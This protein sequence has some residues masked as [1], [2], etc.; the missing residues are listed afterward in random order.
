MGESNLKMLEKV[1]G[2]FYKLSL[3]L[4]VFAT[5]REILLGSPRAQL[6]CGKAYANLLQVVAN[7][8]LFYNKKTSCENCSAPSCMAK[9]LTLPFSWSSS[10][11]VWRV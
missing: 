11:E 3:S 8:S 10:L 6:R 1:F 5:H 9:S 7:A 2:V 4:Q